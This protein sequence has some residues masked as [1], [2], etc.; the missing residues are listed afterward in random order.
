MKWCKPFGPRFGVIG[1]PWP[2]LLPSQDL[3]ADAP[4]AGNRR[5]THHLLDL[6]AELTYGVVFVRHRDVL[7]SALVYRAGARSGPNTM[8]P[9]SLA[10]RLITLLHFTPM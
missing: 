8:E 2:S 3:S 6:S 7:S 4:V 5:G 10:H 1:A 9:G